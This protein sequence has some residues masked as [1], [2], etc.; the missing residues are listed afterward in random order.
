MKETEPLFIISIHDKGF[1]IYPSYVGVFLVVIV[2]IIM[3]FLPL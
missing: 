1:K 3:S 2:P